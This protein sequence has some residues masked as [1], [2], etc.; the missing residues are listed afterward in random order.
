[1]N[2]GKA[3]SLSWSNANGLDATHIHKEKRIYRLSESVFECLIV[4]CFVPDV[5][6]AVHFCKMYAFILLNTRVKLQS[7]LFHVT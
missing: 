6:D 5:H 4:V 2:E 7:P 3:R 1:M